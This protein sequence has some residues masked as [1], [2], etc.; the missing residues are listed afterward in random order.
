MFA[1]AVQIS[2]APR[3]VCFLPEG[4]LFRVQ[5][6][7]SSSVSP[8]ILRTREIERLSLHISATVSQKYDASQ[9]ARKVFRD[10]SN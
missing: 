10:S 8:V 6:R 4:P 9:N 2:L 7:R 1:F 3:Y 5:S